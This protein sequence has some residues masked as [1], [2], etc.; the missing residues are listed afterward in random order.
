MPR[1]LLKACPVCKAKRFQECEGMDPTSNLPSR[2]FHPARYRTKAVSGSPRVRFIR[3]ETLKPSLYP[4][5]K[6]LRSK[7][8]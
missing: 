5:P 1:A 8:I 7:K 6:R 4:P 3:E 2:R